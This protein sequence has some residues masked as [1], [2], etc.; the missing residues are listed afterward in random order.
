MK[1]QPG[2]LFVCTGNVC[3]SPMAEYMFRERIRGRHDW[4]VE[5]AGT[6]TIEGMPA[7]PQAV[8]ALS[9]IGVDLLPHRSRPVSTDMV[10]ESFIVV[11][12]TEGHRADILASI[13]CAADKVYLL[14]NFARDV[15]E[16]DVPDP[17]GYPV[18]VYRQTR[19]MIAAGFDGLEAFLVKMLERD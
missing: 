3:R 2:I 10:A 12:M 4:H 14:L 13:P 15:Q 19:E 5:S 6:S 17:I 1:K 8:T 16:R 18:D 9:E 7:S 11:V